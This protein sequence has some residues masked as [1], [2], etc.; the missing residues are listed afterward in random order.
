MGQS[1]GLGDCERQEDK[2]AKPQ[3]IKGEA[4]P[5]R[6]RTPGEE[7]SSW[8]GLVDGC[9]RGTMG[10]A[11]RKNPAKKRTWGLGHSTGVACAETLAGVINEQPERSR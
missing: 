5:G 6:P 8:P 7:M 9:F 1:P 11:G 3:R 4:A 10:R 2:N